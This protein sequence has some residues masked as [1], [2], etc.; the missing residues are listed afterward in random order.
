VADESEELSM[1]EST[2]NKSRLLGDQLKKV[3]FNEE[4]KN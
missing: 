2:Q 4:Q 1:S 3:Y